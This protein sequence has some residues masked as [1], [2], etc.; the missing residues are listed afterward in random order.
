MPSCT[1][2]HCFHDTL[3][4]KNIRGSL[5]LKPNLASP[6]SQSTH[7]HPSQS[8]TQT[9]THTPQLFIIILDEC[10]HAHVCIR[11]CETCSLPGKCLHILQIRCCTWQRK[12]TDEGQKIKKKKKKKKKWALV[13]SHT[14]CPGVILSSPLCL[15]L[16][17]PSSLS[18][19][20][21]C[22]LLLSPLLV[23]KSVLLRHLTPRSSIS[24]SQTTCTLK[25]RKKKT[26]PKRMAAQE[27][28]G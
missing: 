4:C 17:P 14:V 2:T 11:Q 18:V 16:Q 23:S 26:Q 1:H 7:P 3:H 27:G 15:L 9:H 24:I 20:L 28:S 25:G 21:C 8:P 10:T 6:H 5:A 13:Y 22:L 19:F 12:R